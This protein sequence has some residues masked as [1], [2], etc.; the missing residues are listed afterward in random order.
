ML[1]SQVGDAA[2]FRDCAPS[3]DSRHINHLIY[4]SL[5][6]PTVPDADL[7]VLSL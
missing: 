4:D 2:Q 1:Y 6:L 3:P 5:D 7:W